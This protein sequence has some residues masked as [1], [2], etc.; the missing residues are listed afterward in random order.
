MQAT[1]QGQSAGNV[2]NHSYS[3]DKLGNLLTRNDANTGVAESFQYD[4]LNRLSLYTALGGGLSGVQSVQTL[5]DRAG[6]LKYKS[7]VGYY[8]YDAPR[9][10]RSDH[11]T[12]AHESGRS[13]IGAVTHANTGT[14][15]LAYAFDDTALVPRASP[16]PLR[17]PGL[18]NGT[19]GTP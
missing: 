18:G 13:A 14:R 6:N 1:L 2:L 16:A 8:H 9:P 17:V 10:N 3:Y 4:A 7:D 15:R 5:Y 19:F 12:L 11:I